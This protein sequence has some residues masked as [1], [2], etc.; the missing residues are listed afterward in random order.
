MQRP[1]LLEADGFWFWK[2]HIETY[3]KS[4]DIDLLQVI[5]NGDIVFE[6]EDLETK[7]IKNTT[8]ELLKD[9]QNKK[10]GMNNE[11]NMS[12][13]NVVPPKVEAIEEEKDLAILPLDELISNLK[14]Y[15]MVLDNN[16][17]VSKTT[18]KEKVKSLALKAKVTREQTSDDSDSQ[19]GIDEDEDKTEEFNLMARNF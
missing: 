2:P 7:H 19:G 15:E 8:Y 14:F 4:K 3:I 18:T 11:A 13:Y 10:L 16:D 6:M 17:V 9:D 12:L 5:Q 1:P